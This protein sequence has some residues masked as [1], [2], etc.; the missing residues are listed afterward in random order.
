MDPYPL[1]L[2]LF[3]KLF[4]NLYQKIKK[5]EIAMFPDFVNWLYKPN[6]FYSTI[7]LKTWVSQK[8]LRLDKIWWEFDE[9]ED[10]WVSSKRWEDKWEEWFNEFR[11]DFFG[12]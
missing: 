11:R 7:N 9:Y 4:P 1:V 2:G 3:I 12:D 6:Q 5:K 10:L 8:P